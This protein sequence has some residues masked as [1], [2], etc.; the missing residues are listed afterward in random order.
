[1]QVLIENAAPTLDDITVLTA[2]SAGLPAFEVL[3][4]FSEAVRWL[5]TSLLGLSNVVL[6]NLTARTGPPGYRD[7][8]ATEAA[9][10]GMWLWGLAGAQATVAVP[11]AA[12][13][14]A[15]GNTGLQ[16]RELKVLF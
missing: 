12:Y 11:A 6:V 1:V 15:A 13:A 16:S 2:P 3:L 4:S 14:D 8:N 9:L 5:D 7:T 10:W